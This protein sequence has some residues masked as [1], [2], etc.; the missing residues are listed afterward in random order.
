ML[1]RTSESCPKLA[2]KGDVVFPCV[3]SGRVR[4]GSQ[5]IAKIWC[6]IAR[7]TCCDAKHPFKLSQPLLQRL[8]F[9]LQFSDRLAHEGSI[10]G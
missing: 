5:K 3:G 2:L 7:L 9:L 6:L 1:L 10:P 8:D 4:E